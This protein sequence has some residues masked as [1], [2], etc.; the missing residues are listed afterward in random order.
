MPFALRVSLPK[1]SAAAFGAALMASL[2]PVSSVSALPIGQAAVARHEQALPILDVQA[3]RPVR[4]PVRQVKR[5][6][7]DAALAAGALVG[8]AI[9][10]GAIIA[11]SNRRPRQE[12]YYGA[13]GYPADYYR[14][15][16]P[17]YGGPAY[18]DAPAYQRRPRYVEPQPY[19]APQPR[20]R[21]RDDGGPYYQAPA[22]RWTGGSQRLPDG[23]VITG[24][25]GPGEGSNANSPGGVVGTPGFGN[26]NAY[27]R[28]RYRNPRDPG[29][30]FN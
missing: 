13:P 16:Q 27:P 12:Y 26:P 28:Q 10:G 30:G 23:R 4:R 19:Y 18:Y 20:Q 15:P 8:A 9:I 14:R 24:P 21:W 7:N 3:R 5:R 6:N 17:Y 29:P 11:N 2:I 25:T 22:N 1:L